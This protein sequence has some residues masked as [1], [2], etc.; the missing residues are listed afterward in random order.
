MKI[1]YFD[2][3]KKKIIKMNTHKMELNVTEIV[4]RTKAA[5]VLQ[6]EQSCKQAGTSITLS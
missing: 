2:I 1:F 5:I 6:S 4:L 3:K